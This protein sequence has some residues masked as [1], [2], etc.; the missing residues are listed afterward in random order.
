MAPR[1]LSF[2]GQWYLAYHLSDGEGGGTYC[3]QIV[4]EKIEFDAEWKIS[5]VAP[6]SGISF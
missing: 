3:R 2:L 6:S 5:K 1:S 4:L